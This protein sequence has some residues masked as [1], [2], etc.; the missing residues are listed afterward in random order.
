[1]RI[2]K[3]A[4]AVGVMLATAFGA[5]V[6]VATPAAASGLC[7]S[8]YSLLDTYKLQ[9]GGSYGG[10][11]L[12]LYYNNGW[13]CAYV[14]ATEWVGVPKLMTVALGT[15]LDSPESDSGNYKYFAG[16]VYTYA[17]HQCVSMAGSVWS[18]YDSS[19]YY[20]VDVYNV[21]CG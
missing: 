14:Q 12:Y 5:V 15:D 18:P 8:G 4:L 16:P 3:L 17:P 9:Y 19:E 6:P 2:K 13:N 7:G 21:H 1:M 10:G 20:A 11:T